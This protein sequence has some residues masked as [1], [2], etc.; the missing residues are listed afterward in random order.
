MS[1]VCA[2]AFVLHH[3]FLRLSLLGIRGLVSLEMLQWS[4]DLPPGYSPA[5][6]VS[7]QDILEIPR[8]RQ[9][10]HQTLFIRDMHYMH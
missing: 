4:D 1:F 3:Y 7:P 2:N 8:R 6:E 10:R 9:R 5:K